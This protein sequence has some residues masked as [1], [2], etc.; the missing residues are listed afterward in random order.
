MGGR[1]HC[2]P[3][4]AASP[5]RRVSDGP[6]LLLALVEEAERPCALAVFRKHL[7]RLGLL[8]TRP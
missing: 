1:P 7:G 5:L 6:R 8:P 2:L 4:V 3:G